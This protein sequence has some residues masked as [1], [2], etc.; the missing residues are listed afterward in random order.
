MNSLNGVGLTDLNLVTVVVTVLCWLVF[1]E[2]IKNI[3]EHLFSRY[4]ATSKY[5]TRAEFQVMAAEIRA[6]RGVLVVMAAK[7]GVSDENLKNLAG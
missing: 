7:C 1:Q 2:L 4:K 5:I 6:M 3:I